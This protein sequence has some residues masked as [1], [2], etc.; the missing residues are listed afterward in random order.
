MSRIRCSAVEKVYDETKLN[1]CPL[2]LAEKVH[3]IER[4]YYTTDY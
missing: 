1:F 2:Y 4:F 3:L